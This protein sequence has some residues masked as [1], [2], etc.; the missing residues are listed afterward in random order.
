MLNSTVIE[1]IG[2]IQSFPDSQSQN[3]SNLASYNW[4]YA[5]FCSALVGLTGLVPILLL[6]NQEN[7]RIN[8]NNSKKHQENTSTSNNPDLPKGLRWM[9]S[10]A[11]GG[12]LGDTFLHLL[13]EALASAQSHEEYN[14]VGLCVLFGLLV[15]TI[16]E[17]VLNNS[18]ND[19]NSAS[20]YL[21]L[22][23]NQ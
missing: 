21:N 4:L 7:P 3:S 16:V 8:N 18:C 15:F 22:I 5:A 6:P 11:V 20:G 19:K 14:I 9:L 2:F 23:A 13:P 17:K 1:W 12:L 10:F